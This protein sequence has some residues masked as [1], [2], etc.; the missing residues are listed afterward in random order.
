MRADHV[1][2]AIWKKALKIT[3]LVV[4]CLSHNQKNGGN[5]KTEKYCDAIKSSKEALGNYYFKDFMCVKSEENLE[6]V[7]YREQGI[8]AD[9]LLHEFC[10]DIEQEICR[11]PHYFKAA[12][13]DKKKIINELNNDGLKITEIIVNAEGKSNWF[14]FCKCD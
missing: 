13:Q 3:V 2:V 6:C 8:F 5:V 14:E 11:V 9:Y 4:S 10:A 12:I 1:F 7:D